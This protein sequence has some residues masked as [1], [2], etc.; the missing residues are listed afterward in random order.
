[1]LVKYT[2]NINPTNP[3]AANAFLEPEDNVTKNVTIHI[4]NMNPKANAP[5]SCEFTYTINVPNP[6]TTEPFEK[7]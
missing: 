5:F 1:M 7:L 2:E 6:S 4:K 3:D